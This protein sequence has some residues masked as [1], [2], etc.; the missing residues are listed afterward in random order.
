MK[1]RLQSYTLL[2]STAIDPVYHASM[3][4]F[5]EAAQASMLPSDHVE[6]ST[7]SLRVQRDWGGSH[8]PHGPNRL[9]SKIAGGSRK[10]LAMSSKINNIKGRLK[11]PQT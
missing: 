11:L 5:Y 3:R 7:L 9:P 4:M 6:K 1:Q 8:H 2:I 10:D